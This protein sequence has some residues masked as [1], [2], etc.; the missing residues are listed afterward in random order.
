MPTPITEILTTF[1]SAS[2][3]PVAAT[4]PWQPSSTA[5]ARGQIARVDTVKVRSVLAPSSDTFCTIMSTLIAL[6]ASGPKM[7]GG[8]A[9]PVGDADA[10]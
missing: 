3:A 6:S 10:R 9:R 4:R 5:D 8:D 1:A 7:A 2:S